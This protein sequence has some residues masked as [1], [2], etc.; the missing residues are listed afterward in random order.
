MPQYTELREEDPMAGY[1]VSGEA[2][3]GLKHH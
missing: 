2:I 1:E 3:G